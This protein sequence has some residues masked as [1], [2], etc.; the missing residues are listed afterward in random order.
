MKNPI[1]YLVISLCL[2]FSHNAMADSTSPSL[3]KW[4]MN[5]IYHPSES[6]LKRESKGFVFIYDGFDETQV[7]QIL[8]ARFGRIDHMMFT[9]VKLTDSSGEI[10]LDPETGEELMADDGCD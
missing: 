10:L 3:E 6:V 4:Q 7:D 9:R 5:M 8:D 1:S 2:V